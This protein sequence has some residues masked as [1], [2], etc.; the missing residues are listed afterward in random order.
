MNYLLMPVWVRRTVYYH[1]LDQP[2]TTN[3]FNTGGEPGENILVIPRM[4]LFLW[5]DAEHLNG[6][7]VFG[8]SYE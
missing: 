5:S 7:A 1:H 8:S 2:L 4:G 3:D 6:H